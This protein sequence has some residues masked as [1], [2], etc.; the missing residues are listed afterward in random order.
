MTLS[1]YEKQRL[2]NIKE[3][4]EL[5]RNLDLPQL[6]D[7]KSRSAS[8]SGSSNKKILKQHMPAKK[9]KEPQLPTRSSARLRG[10]EPDLTDLKRSLDDDGIAEESAAKKTKIIDTLDEKDQKRL[11]NAMKTALKDIPNITPKQKEGILGETEEKENSKHEKTDSALRETLEKLQIRHTWTTIKVTPD[12]ITGAL[13]HPSATKLLACAIDTGGYLGIWDIDYQRQEVDDEVE[14]QEEP[15]VY[16]Y[17]PHTRS[18]TDIHFNPTNPSK[19]LTSAYDGYIKVYDMNKAEFETINLNEQ[20]PITTF[21]ITNDGHSLWFSTSEGELGLMDLRAK[22]TEHMIVNPR[23]KKVGCIQLNPT[24]QHL[25]ALSSNDRTLTFWDTRKWIANRTKRSGNQDTVEPLQVVEHGYSVTSCY[26]SPNGKHLATA[27][28]DDYVR[29]FDLTNKGNEVMELKKAIK[30]NNHTGRWVTNFR[31]RWNPNPNYGPPHI[32]IGN[33]K[34]TIDVYSGNTG[35]EIV[36]LYDPDHITAIPSVAQFHPTT[37][38][39]VILT[40]NASGRMV[41]WS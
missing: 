22:A 6:F 17:R 31:A 2:K 20:Y 11:L 3:N 4:E 25:M 29:L 40:G 7:S 1:E 12:R 19:L 15:A 34:Q 33:M 37:E 5:L 27:C 36:Q 26:W 39:P 18:C 30:H 21:D 35:Q 41:C 14:D 9:K 38:N 10:K 24:N 32:I 23:D 13:F 28:Y 8:P 16:Q